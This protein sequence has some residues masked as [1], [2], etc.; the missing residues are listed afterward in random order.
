MSATQLITIAFGAA[1][2]FLT[3]TAF[4]RRELRPF[5]SVAWFSVWAALILVTLFADRLRAIVVPLQA[6]RLLD[7]VIIGAILYLAA[8][9]FLLTRSLRRLET[10]LVELVRQLALEER[11]QPAAGR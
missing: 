2:L 5:E 6:A 11:D 1:M 3:Y 9:T 10:K 8:T 4:R 7:L